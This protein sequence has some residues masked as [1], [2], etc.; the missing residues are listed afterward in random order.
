MGFSC[1]CTSFFFCGIS[2]WLGVLESVTVGARR[3]LG[4]NLLYEIEEVD[5]E[6]NVES[7]GKI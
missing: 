4:M 6:F 2:P 5:S 1:F 3:G 7:C